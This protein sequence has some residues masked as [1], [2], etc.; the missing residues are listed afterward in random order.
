[1]TN[2][3]GLPGYKKP[4]SDSRFRKGVSGN[5]RGRPK[6]SKT[7][8]TL[9]KRALHERVAVHENGKRRVITKA[10]VISKQLINKAASGDLRALSQLSR[11]HCLAEEFVTPKKI[12]TSNLHSFTDQELEA[13]IRGEPLPE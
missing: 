9:M 10:E 13:M 12:D 1:M 5:P 2:D 8:A 4:P 6:G 3:D 7:L 11:L